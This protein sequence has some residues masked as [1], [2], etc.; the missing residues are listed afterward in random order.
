MAKTEPKTAF[1]FPGENTK[2]IQQDYENLTKHTSFLSSQFQ[3]YITKIRKGYLD[4]LLKKQHLNNLQL[5]E[6]DELQTKL[7]EFK[8]KTTTLIDDTA[9]LISQFK[10]TDSTISS[11]TPQ[12][13]PSAPHQTPQIPPPPQN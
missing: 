8:V 7:K 12:G 11:S 1:T 9:M 13:D 3:S 10:S 6:I 2:T 4:P 5:Q